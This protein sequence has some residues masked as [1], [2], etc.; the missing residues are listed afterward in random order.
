M[1][2]G[3]VRP[4]VEIVISRL[5]EAKSEISAM[6]ARGPAAKDDSAFSILRAKIDKWLDLG[7]R[8]TEREFGEFRAISFGNPFMQGPDYY[9]HPG[10]QRQY[11]NDCDMAIHLI[12]SAVE[13]LKLSQGAS[14][15]G[16][17]ARPSRKRVFFGHGHYQAWRDIK[18]FVVERL[19]LDY[20]EFNRD[21][22]AGKSNK[23]RLQ[24]MLETSDFALIVMTGEDETKDGKVRARENVVHEA[25][26]FQGKLGFERAIIL[27][28]NGCE[29]FSNIAGLVQLPFPPGN[30]MAISEEIRRTLE[31]EGLIPKSGK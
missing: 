2:Q 27:R 11:A 8:A 23:E 12:D 7:G 10:H 20:E 25:G 17:A 31:R 18:D 19:G 15:N 22:S 28:E 29:E 26:L 13:S 6:K 4:S 9:H 5:E 30:I 21:P 16:A 3:E 24:E 1:V 14:A